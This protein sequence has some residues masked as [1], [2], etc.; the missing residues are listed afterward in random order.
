MPKYFAS[1]VLKLRGFLNEGHQRSVNAKKNILAS[2]FIKGCSIA[3]SLVL[4]P[5]TIN[6]VNPTRYGIWLTLSSIIGW[7]SFFDIGFGNGLRNKFAE[8]VAKGKFR[9]ARIYVSTTYA[10]LSIIIA[11][12]LILFISINPFLNWTKILNTPPEMRAELGILALLIFVFFCLQFILQLITTIIIANQKP[13]KASFFNLLS[14]IISL[15]II[16]ILTK[17][18]QGNLLYLGIALGLSPVLVLAISSLYFFNGEYK[19]Y[20]PSY[21]FV[22]FSF[23]KNLMSLGMKFF[24]IQISALFLFQTNNIL[25]S[26]FLGPDQVTPYNI[27]F[28]YFG[29]CQLAFLIILSPFWSAYTDAYF[30]NEFIWIK[31][32]TKKLMYFW[33]LLVLVTILMLLCSAFFY[34]LWI[35]DSVRISF[36]LSIACALYVIIITW[37]SIFVNFINGVGKIALQLY[38]SIFIV[39]INVPLSIFLI[40]SLSLGISGLVY[41]N[42]ICLGIGAILGTSQYYKI[43]NKTDVGVWSK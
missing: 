23:A 39:I 42:C 32:T 10:I 21:R 8:A 19:Y 1:S 4:V 16:F 41:S 6:Y 12:I 36:G 27:A 22:R 20:S 31:K 25:I 26:Q 18:T 43:I 40:K 5:L 3:I 7:F 2:F 24:V 13:A 35:G 15:L 14:S 29:I 38:I 28:K 30:R 37:S 17:T 33:L 9:L 11:I 34:H